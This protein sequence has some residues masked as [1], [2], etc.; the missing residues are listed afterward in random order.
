MTGDLQAVGLLV[1]L[2]PRHLVSKKGWALG[3]QSDDLMRRMICSDSM[4]GAMSPPVP[5]LADRS[6]SC[7][8]ISLFPL[9]HH[10][11]PTI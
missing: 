2:S 8:S 4:L 9:S 7:L 6:P 10:L 11:S 1:P 3:Y 5:R